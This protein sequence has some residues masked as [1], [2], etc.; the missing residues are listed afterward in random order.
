MG[1]ESFSPKTITIRPGGAV[2]WRNTSLITHTVTDDPRLAQTPPDSM[3][4][5]SAPAFNSG[6]IPAG[7]I[8]T[9]SFETPGTYH[10]F[11]IHHE[12]DG[13][14]GTVIVGSPS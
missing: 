12:G 2:E 6:D 8:Y 5:A 11:C 1:F 9:R 3:L 14:L 4:P 13:M 7:H 10:Y